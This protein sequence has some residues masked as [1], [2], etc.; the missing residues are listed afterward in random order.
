VTVVVVFVGGSV[1]DADGEQGDG[2]AMR[3]MKECAASESM[4]TEP[5]RRPVRSLSR[6]MPRAAKAEDCAAERLA[7]ELAAVGMSL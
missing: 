7:F 6:V 5:V 2:E 1:R 3:S 4:P